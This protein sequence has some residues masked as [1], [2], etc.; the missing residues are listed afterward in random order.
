MVCVFLIA[1]SYHHTLHLRSE[2]CLRS[3]KPARPIFCR[4]RQG[5]LGWI[6]QFKEI[7]FGESCLISH[8]VVEH[9]SLIV[10]VFSN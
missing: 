10:H 9:Y 6:D 1:E 3:V 5:I 4:V 8:T 7:L 2:R